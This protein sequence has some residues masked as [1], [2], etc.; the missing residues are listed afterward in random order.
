MTIT[1]YEHLSLQK[2]HV[3]G[4]EFEI[5]DKMTQSYIYKYKWLKQNQ[6]I[7]LYML[8]YHLLYCML[9]IEYIREVSQR[10]WQIFLYEWKHMNALLEVRN[11]FGWKTLGRGGG[12]IP[13]PFPHN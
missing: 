7:P 8:I 2:S 9:V 4:W 13:S 1:M 6:A 10:G 12:W 3:C 11:I 5:I